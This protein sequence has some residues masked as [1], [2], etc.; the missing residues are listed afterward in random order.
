MMKTKLLPL[1]TSQSWGER[2]MKI[3]TQQDDFSV[4]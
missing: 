1:R 2:Q 4:V 3:I